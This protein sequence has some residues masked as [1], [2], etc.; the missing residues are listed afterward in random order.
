MGRFYRLSTALTQEQ[1]DEIRRQ[2]RD[3]EDVESVELT[4]GNTC[5][6]VV[7]KDGNFEDVMCSA[8]NI[9]RRVAD[10]ASLSFAGFAYP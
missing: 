5:L 2:M 8:V 1:A 7:T 10:G 3:L 9:C 6:A 4:E